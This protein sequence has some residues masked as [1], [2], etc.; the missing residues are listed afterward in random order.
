VLAYDYPLLNVF[1]SFLYFFLFFMWIWI[2]ITV[3]IDIFRSHDMGGFA[4]ALWIIFVFF[5][6]FL[7]VFVYLIARGSSMH[8]RQ[9]KD[10][11]KSQQAFTEYVQ[12]AAGTGTSTAD[13][14]EKLATLRDS[15]HLTDE[16]FAAQKAKL[17]A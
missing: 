5:I 7:G 12:Q 16:E 3:V 2:A 13:Q 9:V 14:L 1:F 6:P 17:L 10:A 4:K 11:E 15:G 8:E